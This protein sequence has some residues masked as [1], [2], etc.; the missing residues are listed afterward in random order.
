MKEEQRKQERS[1]EQY[2]QHYQEAKREAE[3]A[4]ADLLDAIRATINVAIPPAGLT[5]EALNGLARRFCCSTREVKEAARRIFGPER[6][7]RRLSCTTPE[8]IEREKLATAINKHT[9][10]HWVRIYDGWFI[11]AP[12]G[13]VGTTVPVYRQDGTVERHRLGSSFPGIAGELLFEDGG[14]QPTIPE[15]TRSGRTDK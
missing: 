6:L 4:R 15:C 5:E 10:A 2:A 9:R 12:L 7:K 1:H 13:Q 14:V 3:R 8:K 11:R